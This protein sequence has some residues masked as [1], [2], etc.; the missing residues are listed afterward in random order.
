MNSRITRCKSETVGSHS[1]QANRRSK[2]GFTLAEVVISVAIITMVFAGII[3]GNVQSTKR[4][5]WSGYQLAATALAN[6][7]LEQCRSA[8]WDNGLNPPVNQLT[9]LNLLGWS[10]NASGGGFWRGYSWGDL[11]IPISG[12]NRVRATNWVTIRMINLNNTVVPPVRVQMVQIETVWP[13]SRFRGQR[14]FTNRTATYLAP[15]DRSP[16]SF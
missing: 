3:Q 10:Y 16:A 2:G 15:D 1:D 5:E 14:Y 12:T 9:N 8:L 4:A 6:Q 13:F 11:D 7:Q